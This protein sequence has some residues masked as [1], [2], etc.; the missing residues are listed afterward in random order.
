MG[1]PE[2]G[3]GTAIPSGVESLLAGE[4]ARAHPHSPPLAPES[5][6][7][8]ER[9]ESLLAV[10]AAIP[11]GVSARHHSAPHR[12]H[13]SS[14]TA[15]QSG[16]ALGGG[17]SLCPTKAIALRPH[18]AR[19]G[20]PSGT[21]WHAV[22]QA[23]R[24]SSSSSSR[25][26]S[27]SG[28]LIGRPPHPWGQHMPDTTADP[29]LN[30]GEVEPPHRPQ[31]QNP[32]TRTHSEQM[33]WRVRAERSERWQI[34]PV[35]GLH[36]RSSVALPLGGVVVA[37]TSGAAASSREPLD[38]AAAGSGCVTGR[39]RFRVGASRVLV[40]EGGVHQAFPS[41]VWWSGHRHGPAAVRLSR[42]LVWTMCQRVQ[43]GSGHRSS[44]VWWVGH[45]SVPP[46]C[47]GWWRLHQVR[48]ATCTVGAATV[49]PSQMVQRGALGTMA[50]LISSP[51][52]GLHLT[53]TTDATDTTGPQWCQ[54]CQCC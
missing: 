24:V 26:S 27:R 23:C 14:N 38:G 18:R 15:R 11:R 22:Q 51:P 16:H 5:L 6:F 32:Q 54:L 39:A 7:F 31:T 30:A 47:R 50:T 43:S 42:C 25:S 52:W 49:G 21:S 4:T 53:D 17:T 29:L 12:V 33:H 41:W 10:G 2:F 13:G 8:P 19:N 45:R 3:G 20:T 9:V 48:C 36:V 46:S 1:F 34:P 37:G 28:L 40:G 35:C 44:V